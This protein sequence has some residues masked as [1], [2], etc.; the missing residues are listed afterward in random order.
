MSKP[1]VIISSAYQKRLGKIEDFTS[2]NNKINLID[3]IDNRMS[4]LKIYPNNLLQTFS[5]D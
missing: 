3:L 1:K 5:E 2:D 4:N